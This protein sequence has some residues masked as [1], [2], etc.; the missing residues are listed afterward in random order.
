[1]FIFR[2]PCPKIVIKGWRFPPLFLIENSGQSRGKRRAAAEFYLPNQKP[3]GLEDV[4]LSHKN[5]G[6]RSPG[7]ELTADPDA[8][9]P[10]NPKPKTQKSKLKI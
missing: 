1:M 4:G 9:K 10:Q 6:A 2:N 5:R 7:P 8:P 3:Q